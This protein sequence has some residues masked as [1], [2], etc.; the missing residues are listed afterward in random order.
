LSELVRLIRGFS[1]LTDAERGVL[2]ASAVANLADVEGVDER[3]AAAA[4]DRAAASGDVGLAGDA[5]QVE[6]TVHGRVVVEVG[7]ADL[8]HIASSH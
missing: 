3:E 1:G 8:R 4:L 2:L 7:R 5:H 6:L